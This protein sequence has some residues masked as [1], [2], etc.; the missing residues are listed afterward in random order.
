MHLDCLLYTSYIEH[1]SSSESISSGNTVCGLDCKA[2]FMRRHF[3]SLLFLIKT[4]TVYE[5]SSCL[6]LHDTGIYIISHWIL[7]FITRD[8]ML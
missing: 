4:F 3:G 8:T 2:N 7:H 6:V 1:S 5:R